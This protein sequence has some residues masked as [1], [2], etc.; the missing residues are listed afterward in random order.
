MYIY[1]YIYTLLPQK[2]FRIS[3]PLIGFDLS[4][5][6]RASRSF[7]WDHDPFVKKKFASLTCLFLAPFAAHRSCQSGWFPYRKTVFVLTPVKKRPWTSHVYCMHRTYHCHWSRQTLFLRFPLE[8]KSLRTP[9]AQ[10]NRNQCDILKWNSSRCY[11]P[12]SCGV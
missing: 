4:P 7:P 3:D 5:G 1:I 2:S 11:I 9:C 6:P 10:K 12:S 8:I